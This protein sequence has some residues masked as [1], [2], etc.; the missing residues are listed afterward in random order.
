MKMF[1][2]M[3]A[4]MLARKSF[5]KNGLYL[6]RPPILANLC[7]KKPQMS[8]DSSPIASSRVSKIY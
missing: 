8:C 5:S 6:A 3:Q 4:S 1:C 2:S 7:W